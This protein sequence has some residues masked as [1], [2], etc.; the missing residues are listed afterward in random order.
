VSEV[1][2]ELELV[3]WGGGLREMWKARASIFGEL[4]GVG[5]RAEKGGAYEKADAV[6]P[7]VDTA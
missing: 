2:R 6:L 3:D 1:A 7:R 5:V 4:G